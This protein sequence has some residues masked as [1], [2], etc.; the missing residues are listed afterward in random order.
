MANM[1]NMIYIMLNIVIY[2]AN[3]DINSSNDD[4]IHV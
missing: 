3:N 4:G 2:D 1:A